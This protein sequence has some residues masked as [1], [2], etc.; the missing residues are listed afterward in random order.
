MSQS[1]GIIT[2]KSYTLTAIELA[3]SR[4]WRVEKIPRLGGKIDLQVQGVGSDL[5]DIFVS[6]AELDSVIAATEYAENEDLPEKFRRVVN[7][8]SFYLASF[9]SLGLIKDVMREL[10]LAFGGSLD[11]SW[12]DDDYGRIIPAATFLYKL[13]SDSEWDWRSW[14][15]SI[16]TVFATRKAPE[17]QSIFQWGSDVSGAA[18]ARS[19]L[20]AADMTRIRAAT[21][22]QEVQNIQKMYDLNARLGKGMPT[23]LERAKFMA[24]ILKVW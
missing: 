14:P 4:H 17:L 19:T 5:A 12:I 18:K 16:R 9:N 24:D 13:T 15:A 10:L 11:T 2:P 20:S 22:S 3:I 6:I 23:A 1:I 7:E 21:T 8:S